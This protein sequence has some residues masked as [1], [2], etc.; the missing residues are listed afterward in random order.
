MFTSV[1]LKTLRDLRRSL[2][3]W[4]IGIVSLVLVMAAV[5]PSM[6][7]MPDLEEFLSNYPEVMQQLFDFSAIT[8][9]PG[10]LNAELY[11]MLL[12]ALFMIFGIGRGARLIAGEEADGTL[13]VLVVTPVSRT[14]VLFEKAAALAIALLLLALVLWVSVLAASAAADLGVGV[15]DA[16][17]GSVAM[18]LLGLLFGWLAMAVGAATGRRPLAL[19]VAATA[20]VA[21]YVLHVLGALVDAIEPWQPLSPF[22]R[23]VETGPLGPEFPLGFV[24]LAVAA[25]LVIA[26][27]VP[28]FDRRDIRTR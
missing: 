20:A 15:R 14:R 11:S 10:F 3:G 12:P 13:D 6:R 28:V 23:A 22:T 26:A 8:T 9:G 17:A 19:G 7:D 25:L 16:T 5:W 4:S 21:S 24:W 18:V 27:T 1:F 2:L